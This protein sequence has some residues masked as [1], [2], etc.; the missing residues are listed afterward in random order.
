MATPSRASEAYVKCLLPSTCLVPKIVLVIQDWQQP[1]GL[2][3][4]L[5]R[6]K[7]PDEARFGGAS[8]SGLRRGMGIGRKTENGT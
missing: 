4:G 5:G 3:G 2:A 8:S 7:S 6:R 1:K